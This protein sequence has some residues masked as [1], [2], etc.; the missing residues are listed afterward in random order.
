M[1]HVPLHPTV[2]LRSCQGEEEEVL[3]WRDHCTAA[4]LQCLMNTSNSI[5]PCASKSTA[6]LTIVA[7]M[8]FIFALFSNAFFMCSLQS[9]NVLASLVP[10]PF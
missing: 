7:F 5:I 3:I 10:R 8:L 1:N 2:E 9:S 6:S 4:V